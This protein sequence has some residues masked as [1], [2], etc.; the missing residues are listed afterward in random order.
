MKRT[1]R[2]ILADLIAFPTVSGNLAASHEA[3]DYIEHSLAQHGLHIQRHSWNGYPSLVATTQHT[4]NPRVLLAAHLDVVPA[5]PELFKLTKRGGKFYGRGT[6]DM[7]FAI[8]AY[9]QLIDDLSEDLNAYDLGIMITADEEIG[10]KDGVK[11][12]L[13]KGGYRADVCVLPD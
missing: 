3:L 10:G 4:K 8:A 6:C 13:E 2:D 1:M 11:A 12:L 9:L 5:P 7:K